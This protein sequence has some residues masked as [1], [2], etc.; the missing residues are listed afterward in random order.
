MVCATVY[1]CGRHL[2]ELDNHTVFTTL[3]IST[4]L[5][6]NLLAVVSSQ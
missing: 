4:C 1:A 5:Q 3:V 2:L 6:R